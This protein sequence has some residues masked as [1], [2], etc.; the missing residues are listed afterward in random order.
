MTGKKSTIGVRMFDPSENGRTYVMYMYAYIFV[1]TRIKNYPYHPSGIIVINYLHVDNF[2]KYSKALFW[3]SRK[4]ESLM[5]SRTADTFS[6]LF[7][8]K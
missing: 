5:N 2:F 7:K 3:R 8:I 6:Q 4:Y 1:K